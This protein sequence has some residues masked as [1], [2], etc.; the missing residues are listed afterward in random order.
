MITG[1]LATDGGAHSAE[2]WAYA[3]AGMLLEAF[4]VDEKSPRRVQMEMAKDRA[5]PKIADVLV[6]HH[7]AIQAAE[8]KLLADGA[9]D[10]L[11]ADLDPTE[12]SDIEA[13]I[14]ETVA[15]VVPLAE[16]ATLFSTAGGEPTVSTA[17]DAIEAH[18]ALIV[19]QRVEA[20]F[21]TVMHIERSWH[22][23]RNPD[24]PAAVAFRAA[25]TATGA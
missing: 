23:D 13:A 17:K 22:A 24:H 2:D 9:H 16:Q 4:K 18:I 7:D 14:A 21:R 12:H 19:R 15:I 6:K 11:A 8:R 1:L 5:R 25:A 20:D 3:S 10:R